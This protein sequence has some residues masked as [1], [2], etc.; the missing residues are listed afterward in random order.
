MHALLRL[1][2]FP[3]VPSPKFMEVILGSTPPHCQLWGS[4]VFAGLMGG[5]LSASPAA[6]G[7]DASS[8][9]GERGQAGETRDWQEDPCPPLHRASGKKTA[10]TVLSQSLTLCT[11]LV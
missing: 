2:P 1:L 6:I 7:R 10:G 4:A 9:G 3:S 11:F 5:D 8:E